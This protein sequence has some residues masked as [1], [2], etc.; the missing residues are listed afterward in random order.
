[1]T[2]TILEDV[3]SPAPRPPTPPDIQK[4]VERI[5]FINERSWTSYAEYQQ[6]MADALLAFQSETRLKFFGLPR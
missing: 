4:W 2:T 1:M 5:A 6:A 3:N